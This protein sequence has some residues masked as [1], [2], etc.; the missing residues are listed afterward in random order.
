M[1]F[2]AIAKQLNSQ[3]KQSLNNPSRYGFKLNR[4]GIMQKSIPTNVCI[5][6]TSGIKY[7]G[8]GVLC[9]SDQDPNSSHPEAE[10][11]RTNV[12]KQ[13]EVAQLWI[14]I[15]NKV[16]QLA[17]INPTGVKSLRQGFVTEEGKVIIDNL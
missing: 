8:A 3:R 15:K 6:T 12:W 13:Y 1:E 2:S 11:I 10:M 4:K 17:Q 7:L 14:F 16:F 5:R 9:Y